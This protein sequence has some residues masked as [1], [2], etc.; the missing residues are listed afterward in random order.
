MKLKNGYE[1]IIRKAEKTDAQQLIDYLATVR[2][3][4][5]NLLVVGTNPSYF[6]Q[7]GDLC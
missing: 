3:E 7:E 2:G 4:T 5:D 6:Q 1:L